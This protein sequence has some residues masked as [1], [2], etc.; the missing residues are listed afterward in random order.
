MEYRALFDDQAGNFDRRAGLPP[1]VPERVAVALT[2]IA[3]LQDGRKNLVEIGAGT[4]EIGVHLARRAHRY[5]GLD[6][7]LPMLRAFRTRETPR[8]FLLQADGCA[9]WPLR[10]GSVDVVFG[11]RSLHHL[12]PAHLAGELERVASGPGT[13]LFSGG[14]QREKESVK[15]M[16]SHRMRRLLQDRGFRGHGGGGVRKAMALEL[17]SR[18]WRPIGSR[19]VSSWQRASSPMDS[20]E[21]WQGKAGLNGLEMPVEVKRSVLEELRAWAEGRFGNLSDPVTATESY[22][23][24]GMSRGS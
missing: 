1:D 8:A 21:S 13:V 22:V 2:E 16:M 24:V 17:E 15:E 10:P 9:T 5:L 19:I 14:L 20:L 4:G 3:G 11:S 6:L 12:P 7:S 23:L 18:G